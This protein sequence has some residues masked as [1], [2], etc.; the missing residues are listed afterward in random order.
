MDRLVISGDAYAVG[1][2]IGRHMAATI[3]E[4]VLQ[5]EE[6]RLLQ[7]HW[8]NTSYLEELEAAARWN[9]PHYVRE[10]EGIA[11][12]AG[13]GFHSLFLWNCR[14]DLRFPP[15]TDAQTL[16]DAGNG[17][18]TVFIPAEDGQPAIIG[19]NED[20]ATEF[21]HR[22]LWISV[23]PERGLA[24]ESF[25]YPGML[26]GHAFGVNAA[27]LVQT[28]NNIRAFDLKPGIPR[29]FIARAVLDCDN[30]TAA[31]AQLRRND[32][33]GGFHHGLAQAGDHALLSVEAPAG[34][35]EV[36]EIQQ[37]FAHANHLIAP[38]F[39]TCRQ[40]ITESSRQRQKWA[41][42]LIAAGALGERRPETVLFDRESEKFAI[43][44]QDNHAGDYAQTLATGV[45]RIYRERI[46]WSVHDGPRRRDILH[47]TQYVNQGYQ[48]AV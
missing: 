46:D 31:L 26:A 6:F 45:F 35:C 33:A 38:A 13:V 9:F 21:Y 48:R 20:G 24:F 18:T 22:C 19:H 10:L 41:D 17:C 47:C 7:Q 27:G 5:H 43:Y 1:H 25:V 14:G 2:A 44:R 40:I 8:E 34:G 36:R 30:L 42:T 15:G 29:H 4:C 16:A 12:G 23:V 37:P 11:A 39:K 28:I 3:H 32:R